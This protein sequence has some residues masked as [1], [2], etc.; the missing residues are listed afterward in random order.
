MSRLA[1]LQQQLLDED[2]ILTIKADVIFPRVGGYAAR[3][4]INELDLYETPRPSE[5]KA[6][7]RW[8]M[9]VTLSGLYGGSKYYDELDKEVSK[10]LGSTEK[11]SYFTIMVDLPAEAEDTLKDIKRKAHMIRTL[12]TNIIPKIFK[13]FVIQWSEKYSHSARIRYISLSIPVSIRFSKVK[14]RFFKK[15]AKELFGQ[16]IPPKKKEIKVVIKT[17]NTLKMLIKKLNINLNIK[18]DDELKSIL[19]IYDELVNIA[20][21]P[22]MSI[23]L[24]PRRENGENDRFV[25]ELSEENR[26][27]LQRISED[28]II[29]KRMPFEIIVTRNREIGDNTEF[30]F[31]ITTLL[32]SLIL[33][34]I[35]SITRRGFGS[36]VIKEVE[37]GDNYKENLKEE[38]TLIEKILNASN[39]NELERA[40]NGYIKHIINLGRKT[41]SVSQRDPQLPEVPSLIPDS[42]Y[43]R[44]KVLE[45]KDDIIEILKDFGRAS[46]KSEWKKIVYG[47]KATRKTGGALHTWILGLPRQAKYKERGKEIYTGYFID[48]QPGRRPSAISLKIFESKQSKK[49]IIVYGFL[50]K[51]WP[52]NKLVHRSKLYPS[53]KKVKELDLHS[54]RRLYN[55]RYTR[56][57][58]REMSDEEFLREVFN[59]AFEFILQIL[60]SS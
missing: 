6:L 47:N 23:L 54:L 11:T 22:R 44:L 15:L 43:F 35:G 10:I 33:G 32:L 19:D 30:R 2:I 21:I 60:E 24:Q 49:F 37:I 56:R 55:K 28:L 14:Y 7:W 41:F 25:N 38:L 45:F 40:L 3:P 57:Y 27:Y 13:R 50:S 31:A 18:S 5:L 8:W 26:K 16:D 51:D 36:I 17:S 9:R 58:T 53:G 29:P 34:G 59:T 4:Y 46:L 42:D 52:L 20:K 12:L 48:D 1:E 39:S